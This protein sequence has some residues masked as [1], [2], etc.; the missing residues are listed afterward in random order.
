MATI[1]A[2]I[3]PLIEHTAQDVQRLGRAT[4]QRPATSR[5]HA[6]ISDVIVDSAHA[7]PETKE[8]AASPRQVRPT[9]PLKDGL[10]VQ[11]M[12]RA[13]PSLFALEIACGFLWSPDLQGDALM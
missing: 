4:G 6:L 8:T 5:Q 1:K 3:T 12:L 7:S 13:A 11:K 2:Q 9:K 10:K